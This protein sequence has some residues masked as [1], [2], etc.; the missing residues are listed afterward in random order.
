MHILYLSQYFPPE[1][2]ATQTRAYEMSRNL[3]LMGH[4]VTGSQNCQT[5]HPES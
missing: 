4:Q 5:T 1:G 3:V 2:G